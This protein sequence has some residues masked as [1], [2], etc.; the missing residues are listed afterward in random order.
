MRYDLDKLYDIFSSQICK[1]YKDSNETITYEYQYGYYD[2]NKKATIVLAQCQSSTLKYI[3]RADLIN[4]HKL[5]LQLDKNEQKLYNAYMNIAKLNFELACDL[6]EQK[7]Y[8]NNEDKKMLRTSIINN[9]ATHG[10]Q[11]LNCERLIELLELTTDE[12]N[13]ILLYAINDN[14]YYDDVLIK[15]YDKLTNIHKRIILQD[16]LISNY[17]AQRSIL[18]TKIPLEF[19]IQIFQFVYKDHFDLYYDLFAQF[20]NNEIKDI[21]RDILFKYVY[22]HTMDFEFW[23]NQ[24]RKLSSSELEL[25]C[26]KFYNDIFNDT[27]SFKK[28]YYNCLT[29]NKWLHKSERLLLIQKLKAKTRASKI[30]YVKSHISFEPDELDILNSIDLRNKLL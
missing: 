17:R 24:L 12:L 15:F 21:I 23:E 11:L 9:C 29:F 6:F 18:N 26:N 3:L 30:A 25:I 5:P 4:L 13:K 16:L 22:E 8:I 20:Y 2:N 19:R 28:F 1:L 10:T 7:L 14:Y 27:S